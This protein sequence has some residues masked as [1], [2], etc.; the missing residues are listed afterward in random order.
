MAYNKKIKWVKNALTA[1]GLAYAA[2][3]PKVPPA[4]NKKTKTKK[5]KFKGKKRRRTRNTNIYRRT[6]EA[7]EGIDINYKPA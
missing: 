1:G 4:S 2:M 6:N 7:G 5:R 3:A